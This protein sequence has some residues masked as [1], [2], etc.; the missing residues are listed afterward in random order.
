M[1]S[2]F[3]DPVENPQD[4]LE[5][6]DPGPADLT[7]VIDRLGF[8][9]AQIS[10]II[11]SGGMWMGDAAEVL[12]VSAITKAMAND[13]GM[14][15]VQQSFVV[16]M[17]YVGV[18]AGTFVAGLFGDHY[19]RRWP[20]LASMLGLAGFNVLT[21]CATGFIS[22]VLIRLFIGISIG[23]GQ[24]PQV[25]L[26]SELAP[27]NRREDAVVWS[28]VLFGVGELYAAFF[29]W[30]QDPMMKTLDWRQLVVFIAIP[31]TIFLFACFY[32]LHESPR[33]LALQGRDDEVQAFLAQVRM[34]NNRP[35]VS[36][37][38]TPI[39]IE[40]QNNMSE[41]WCSSLKMLFGKQLRFITIACCFT[42]FSINLLYVGTFYALPLLL[43]DMKLHDSPGMTLIISAIWDSVGILS[44]FVAGRYLLRRTSVVIFTFGQI[45]S[46]SAFLYASKQAT[47][48]LA[49]DTVNQYV[50]EWSINGIKFFT[51]AVFTIVFMFYNEVF[52][53]I[54]RS[55]GFGTAM[56]FGR[57]GAIG[58]PLIFELVRA[59]ASTDAFFYI[60]MVLTVGNFGFFSGVP[61]TKNIKLADTFEDEGASEIL[62]IRG[63]GS[64]T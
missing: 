28:Q 48:G 31:P 6:E 56:T 44:S 1:A 4:A 62:P 30:L 21:L 35:N 9:C 11:I 46:L 64:S 32:L 13:W 53:T 34:C 10:Q 37:E 19:G 57:L 26:S 20:I 14:T 2:N 59:K 41:Q 61:E 43:P 50:L 8:G 29:I 23:I 52:P 16:S 55:T 47:Q 18:L 60:A 25:A 36:L 24:P 3:S 27:T 17:V 12:I 33:V 54:A 22:L 39:L 63:T 49:G 42:C 38:F 40:R 15:P 58:A 45:L 5:E 51:S 7:R